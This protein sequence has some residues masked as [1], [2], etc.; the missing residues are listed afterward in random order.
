MS[1]TGK[2]YRRTVAA[3]VGSATIRKSDRPERQVA[4]HNIA[5][6]QRKPSEGD[7]P[8][9]QVCPLKNLL[10]RLPRKQGGSIHWISKFLDQPTKISLELL[11]QR[12]ILRITG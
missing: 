8:G 3:H 9:R 4:Y 12:C 7:C 2:R 1:S 10:S 5:V 11:T 6:R